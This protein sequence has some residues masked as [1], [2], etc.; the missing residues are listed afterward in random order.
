M[1]KILLCGLKQCFE[2]F[3]ILTAHKCPDAELFS[4]LPNCA[5]CSLEFQKPITFEAHLQFQSIQGFME[6]LEMQE[7]IEKIFFDFYII[8][9]ELVALNTRFY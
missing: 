5:F 6:I 3:N 2:P 4:R 8:A 9:F 1:T 7:K